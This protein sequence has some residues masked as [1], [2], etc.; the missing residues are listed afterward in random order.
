MNKK[1]RWIFWGIV[2]ACTVACVVS[3]QLT[4]N[5]KKAEV[6]RLE[7]SIDAMNERKLELETQENTYMS[8]EYIEDIAR[9]RLG[10]VR[11][12]EVVFRDA[13]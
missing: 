11:S 9:E 3:Q 7:E 12:D 5:K 6:A 10:Y 2:I 13:D 4:I 8:D 1:I